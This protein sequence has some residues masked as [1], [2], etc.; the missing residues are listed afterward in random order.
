MPRRAPGM[1]DAALAEAGPGRRRR[2]AL[3][4]IFA[5]VLSF[6]ISLGGLVPWMAL[7]LEARGTEEAVIGIVCAANPFGVMLAAPL[8]PRLL[9]R[10]GTADAILGGIFVSVVTIALLPL[11]DSVAG[12]LVLR[13]VS[14]LAASVP[15]VVT[16][17]WINVVA[18]DRSRARVIALYGT[19]MAVGFT[20]GPVVLTVT[21]AEGPAAVLCFAALNAS[22]LVPIFLVRRLAPIVSHAESPRLSGIALAMPAILAAAFLSGAVDT[23]FFGFL[24]IWGMRAGLDETFAVTLLSVFVAGNVLLQLPLGWLADVLGYRPVMLVCGL[25]SILGPILT[26]ETIELP[27]VLCVVM[28]VWGGML[29]G[30]YTI[31]LAALGQRFRNGPLA[32]ANAAFVMVYTLANITG[33]PLAGLAIAAW[34]PHGLIVLMLGFAVAFTG[35]VLWRSVTR[36]DG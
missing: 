7:S 5:S 34:D 19:I 4:A 29:W 16:E 18:G 1:N 11:F 15:W 32:A 24:P 31:G 12:W 36:R 26:L 21:G 6:S 9:R 28:F 3:L 23:A 13:L 8:V 33:P 25:A 35:L 14:G 17:T 22:A 2:L 10:I 27:T 30:T 20:T